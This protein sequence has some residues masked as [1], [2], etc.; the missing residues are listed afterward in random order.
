MSP[1]RCLVP[2]AGVRSVY[3]QFSAENIIGASLRGGGRPGF[4]ASGR[5]DR[6]RRASRPHGPAR[7]AGGRS[8]RLG[9][10]RLD[11]DERGPGADDDRPRTG[12]FL[13]RAGAQEKRALHHDAKLRHDGAGDRAVGD[14]RLQP[15]VRARQR[16][17]WRTATR[18][19]ARGGRSAQPGLRPH[20]S[21]ADVHDL[22]AHVRHHHPGAHFRGLRRAHE[23]QRHGAVHGVVVAVRL[24]PHGAHGMGQGRPAERRAGRALPHPGFCR[25]HGSARHLGSFGAGVR[26]GIWAGVSAIPRS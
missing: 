22:P 24:C 17:H 11:A 13:W 7:A 6:R 25:R 4:R 2:P 19:P 18:V 1:G 9:R 21:A 16:L 3:A 5:D 8:Q 12:A 14:H 26:A 15:G 10:Q 23:V 20:H